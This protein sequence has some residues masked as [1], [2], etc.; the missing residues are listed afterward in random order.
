MLERGESSPEFE[1]EEEEE[2]PTRAGQREAGEEREREWKYVSEVRVELVLLLLKVVERGEVVD[3]E[4]VE[5][6]LELRE[7]QGCW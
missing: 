4:R 3:E 1:E 5:L 6:V 2:V 7:G